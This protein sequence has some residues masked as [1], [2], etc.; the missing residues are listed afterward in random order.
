[1]G[2]LSSRGK[3]ALLPSR[4]VKGRE[5]TGVQGGDS[6]RTESWV[7]DVSGMGQCMCTPNQRISAPG[8][9]AGAIMQVR[10]GQAVQAEWTQHKDAEKSGRV[11]PGLH[12]GAKKEMVSLFVA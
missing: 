2:L 8:P 6:R 3:H 4:G 12:V 10:W 9:A 11:E 7:L 5:R 1:M